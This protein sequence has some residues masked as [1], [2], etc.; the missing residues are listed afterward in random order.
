MFP[1]S[2]KIQKRGK[3][4]ISDDMLIV[5]WECTSNWLIVFVTSD[6]GVRSHHDFICFVFMIIK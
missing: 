1:N 4:Q 6:L 2:E 5:H 3:R